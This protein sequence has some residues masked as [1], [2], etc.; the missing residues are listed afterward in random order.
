MT[1]T[2]LK[3][4]TGN[5]LLLLAAVLVALLAM[6]AILRLSG[7]NRMTARFMCFDAVLGKVYCPDAEGP[8]SRGE[9]THHLKTSTD[10]MVDR[11]YPAEKPAGTIRIAML[12]DSFTASEYLPARDKFEG[13][14]ENSLS[15]AAGRP[16]E[17][18]NF[19]ISASETWDQLQIFHLRAIRYTPDITLLVFFWGNDIRDNIGKLESGGPNPLEDDYDAPLGAR[20]REL[21]KN[22]NKMLWN[23]SLLYQL[24]H[25]GFGKL[26]RAIKN[27]FVP[28][29][30]RDIERVIQVGDQNKAPMDGEQPGNGPRLD[31]PHNDDDL[32]F[33][34]SAGWDITRK[35]IVKLKTEVEAAGSRLLVLHFPSVGL[36]RS[37]I[38]LPHGEFDAFLDRNDIPHISLFPDYQGMTPEELQRHFIPVDGHWTPYGHRFVAERLQDL[39]LATIED[40][41]P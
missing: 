22:F 32:F 16:V 20:F 35:L 23:H 2:T 9:Y 26:E 8:F 21:R 34:D 15:Q 6:E 19:G 29:Y 7:A 37:G 30:I 28:D 17:I 25:E 18:L 40:S 39:L 24:S 13:L 14:L 27:L 10:G 1:R 31:T 36:V 5:L 11:T 38:P 41:E 4:K 3:N 12:G 33:P